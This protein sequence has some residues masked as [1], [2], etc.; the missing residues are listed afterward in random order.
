MDEFKYLFY[1]RL[2]QF[3]KPLDERLGT[4]GDLTDRKNLR[5]D[6]QCKSFKWFLD[7]IV[8][9][10]LPY[11]SLIG[12]GELVN[13]VSNLCV[14]K[15]DRTEHMDEPVDLLPCHNLGGFQYWWYNKNR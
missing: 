1:G 7:T 13:P 12:G 9:G 11:H 5:N 10:R 14:D 4:I 8:A 6:L 3:D 15:N 2:G